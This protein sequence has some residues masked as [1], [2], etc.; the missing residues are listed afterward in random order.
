MTN[1]QRPIVRCAPHE[2]LG[3][4]AFPSGTNAVV[5]VLSYTGYDMEDAMIINKASSERG[6]VAGMVFKTYTVSAKKYGM[7]FAARTKVPS[8]SKNSRHAIGPDG[9]PNIGMVL[10]KGDVL[11]EAISPATGDS[12]CGFYKGLETA[13]VDRVAIISDGK[14]IASIAS[15]RLRIDRRCVIC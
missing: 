5:A 2:V 11:W 15:I 12:K 10:N 9:L 1:P 14:R 13:V 7:H 6:F 3:L 8:Y 4:D